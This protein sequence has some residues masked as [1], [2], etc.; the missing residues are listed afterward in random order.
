G[1]DLDLWQVQVFRHRG[2]R[3]WLELEDGREI[4]VPQENLMAMMV[5]GSIVDEVVSGRITVVSHNSKTNLASSV[6]STA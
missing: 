2:G 3:R 6:V 5:I 1:R 4:F